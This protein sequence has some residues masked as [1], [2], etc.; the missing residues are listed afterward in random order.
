MN[1]ST[2]S[3]FDPGIL[4]AALEIDDADTLTSFYDMF[5]MVTRE[6]WQELGTQEQEKD[7]EFAKIKD[8][9]H[10]LKSSSV[11]IGAMQ[12]ADAFK[13]LERLAQDQQIKAVTEHMELT[14]RLVTQSI[15]AVQQHINTLTDR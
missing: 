13:T 7:L 5:I 15:N 14:D 4:P 8:I 6:S 1:Q 9:A 12:L 3:L 2:L 10:K 11:S